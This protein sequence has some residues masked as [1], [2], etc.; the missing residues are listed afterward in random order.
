MNNEPDFT[1]FTNCKV[2][3]WGL[4]LIGG[5]LAYTLAGKCASLIGIDP[6]RPTVEL[7]MTSNIFNSVAQKPEDVI[8]EAN[9]II[10]AAPVC[11][12]LE[13]IKSLPDLHPGSCVVLDLGST[14]RKIMEAMAGLPSR[15]EPVGGHPMCGNEKSSFQHADA[16]IFSNAN[17]ALIKLPRTSTPAQ[18]L[19][20]TMVHQTGATPL[21][22][23]AETH[24]RWTAQTSHMPYLVANA[25][26]ASIPPE[27]R[28]MAGSGLRSTS[29]LAASS[30]TMMLDILMTNQDF[31][32]EALQDF[33]I[34]LDT[35]AENIR[36]GDLETL[37]A[38]L[39]QGCN[40]RSTLFDK[41]QA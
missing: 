19:A 11:A 37:E 25:L 20:E 41:G 30:P 33:N 23:D 38:N 3:I 5:S 27:A 17:F 29:R 10:L 12:I 36:N 34:K 26:A 13:Q 2:A 7:A 40:A 21:W 16:S 35:L 22:L 1:D 31:L 9:L 4:G 15:F 6:D 24:D 39:Q 28:P 18:L 8:A 32:L 14:K